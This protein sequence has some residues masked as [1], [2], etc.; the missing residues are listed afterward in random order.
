MDAHDLLSLPIGTYP[1]TDGI[2][3]DKLQ[4]KTHDKEDRLQYIF[5]PQFG[6]DFILY[7]QEDGYIRSCAGD[8]GLWVHGMVN[9]H[10]FRFTGKRGTKNKNDRT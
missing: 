4:V 1:I 5:H 6:S 10:E 3:K 7:P 8:G 9:M 2:W